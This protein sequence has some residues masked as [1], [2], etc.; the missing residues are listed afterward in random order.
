MSERQNE[1]EFDNEPILTNYTKNEKQHKFNEIIGLIHEL[2][3][4]EEFCSITINTGKERP[5]EVNFAIKK[6]DFD[7]INDKCNIGDKVKIFFFPTSKR[8]KNNAQRFYNNNNIIG[9][10]RINFNTLSN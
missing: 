1:P 8:D 4:G 6:P 7:I 3:D 2:N 9:L 10:E 5:R